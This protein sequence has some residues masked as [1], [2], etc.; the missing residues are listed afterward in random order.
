VVGGGRGDFDAPFMQMGKPCFIYYR[1]RHD[2]LLVEILDC[3]HAAR[4]DPEL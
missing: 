4:L 3:W 2:K 1:V